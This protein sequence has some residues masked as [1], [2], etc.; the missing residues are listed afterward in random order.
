MTMA[1]GSIQAGSAQ[2]LKAGVISAFSATGLVAGALATPLAVYLPNY[3]ASHVGVAIGLVGLIFLLIKLVDIGFDP[4]MGMVMGRTRT[5]IGRYRFW[6][7]LSA[8]VIMVSAYMNFMA[9]PGVGGAYVAIWLAV[10]YLGYSLALLS[11]A[12]WGAM[13]AKTYND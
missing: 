4:M 10:L 9:R 3:Y 7:L 11:Q 1:G 8:P 12:A 6:L 13:I 2:P 5:P